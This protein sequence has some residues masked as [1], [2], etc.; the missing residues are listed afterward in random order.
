VGAGDAVPRAATDITSETT[1]TAVGEPP[2]PEP[3]NEVSPP[4]MPRTVTMF[5]LPSTRPNP[6]DSGTS[7]GRTVA[8]TVPLSSAD[9]RAIWR[10][11][12]PSSRAYSKSTGSIGRIERVA[13]SV[14]RTGRRRPTAAI[15]A[16]FAAASAPSMSS[17]GSASA[18][19]AFCAS[20]STS[21]NAT[22][23]FCIR[24]RM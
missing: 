3:R 16:S 11:V 20:A 12:Q 6:D 22:R 4:K 15:I 18:Y 23:S 7:A 19:P 14:T 21:L 5:W 17:L 2:A 24:L 13:M 1:A 9:A 8:N 10:M